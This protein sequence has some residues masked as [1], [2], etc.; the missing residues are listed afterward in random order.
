MTIDEARIPR[1]QYSNAPE[2]EKVCNKLVYI[3][4]HEREIFKT[5]NS[6]GLARAIF[7]FHQT[8]AKT[9]LES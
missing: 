3:R 2:L 6:K 4:Q 8:L 5:V 9:I 1:I 7:F